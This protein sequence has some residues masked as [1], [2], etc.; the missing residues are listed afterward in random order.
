MKKCISYC[1]VGAALLGSMLMVMMANKK[2]KNFRNFIALLNDDQQQVYKSVIN[3]R[4]NIYIQGLSLG[5][6]LAILVTY[7]TNLTKGVN[8]C[9]F[10]VVSLGINCLYYALYPK[11]TY[12]LK[13]LTSSDQVNAWLSIYKEM[14]VRNYVGMLLGILGYLLI[15]VGWCN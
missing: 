5:I 12:M 14:K 15:G 10:I 7:H 4:M 1:L 9:I 11:S 6:I 2:S 13:H 3:E 8:V